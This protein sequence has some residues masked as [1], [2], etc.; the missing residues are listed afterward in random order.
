VYASGFLPFAFCIPY[1]LY[2]PFNLHINITKI[3]PINGSRFISPIEGPGA[4]GIQ[5]HLLPTFG[6]KVWSSPLEMTTGTGKHFLQ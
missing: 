6:K 2:Q 5:V 3:Y 1:Q 4:T